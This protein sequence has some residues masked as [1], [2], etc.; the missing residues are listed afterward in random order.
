V[1]DV[2]R[3]RADIKAAVGFHSGLG[4]VAPKTDAKSIKARILVCIGSDDPFIPLEQ[5][6]VFEA[7]MRDA[8][9]DWQMNVYGNTVHSFTN[10]S[11]ANAKRPNAV[12]YSEEADR[13]SW[14][15]MQ[16]LFAEAFS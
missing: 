14:K 3:S 2:A 16:N 1:R 11:A 13:R 8:S 6:G 7:E 10:P 4:T 9:V 15:A 5:R 12:R